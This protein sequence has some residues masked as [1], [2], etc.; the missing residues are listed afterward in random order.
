MAYGGD[1]H[2]IFIIMSAPIDPMQPKASARPVWCQSLKSVTLASGD[3]L[4]TRRF[5]QGALGMSADCAVVTDQAAEALRQH[6]G[7]GGAGP[8]ELMSFSRPGLAGALRLRVV[9]IDPAVPVARP[10]L[11]CRYDGALG[12]G[13]PVRGLA[14]RHQIVEAMG[15]SSTAGVT[16]MPFP[17][18]DGSMYDIGEAHWIAPDDVMVLGVDRADMQPVGPIDPALD[19]GGPSYSSMLVSDAGRAAA[20]FDGVL[21]LELRREFTFESEGPSGGMGLPGGTQV[22][23]QQWFS[24]GA[25]T[26]YLVVMQLQQNARRAPGPL[27]LQRRGIG[28]WSFSSQ[29]LDDIVTR[30]E[31]AESGLTRVLSAP[32]QL[33]VPGEGEVRAMVI[34]TPDGFPIEITQAQ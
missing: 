5:Y 31:R 27:G 28:L 3:L 12:V 25:T 26:G 1:S 20:F 4:A 30:A 18:P 29:T 16:Y 22:H 7:L 32:R 14:K 6:W 34:A 9:H 17:R 24:P 2:V 11:D 33:T 21:G 15:F 19:L 23:F 10:G 8:I 13:F